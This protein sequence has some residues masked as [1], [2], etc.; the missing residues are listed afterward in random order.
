MDILGIV[1]IL[2]VL[3]ALVTFI[4]VIVKSAK[5]WGAIHVTT[6]FFLFFAAWVFLFS[7]AGVLDTRVKWIRSHDTERAAVEN[8]E[9]EV[10]KIK[11]GDLI[12]TNYDPNS[13]NATLNELGRMKLDRGRIWRGIQLQSVDDN[14]ASY[15]LLAPPNNAAA[16]AAPAAP[17]VAP[18]APPADGGSI[19]VELVVYAFAETKSEDGRIVPGTYLGQFI[20]ESV[21]GDALKL[22]P[23]EELTEYQNATISGGGAATWTVFE[24][25]PLDSHTAFASKGSEQN[26]KQLFGRMDPAELGTLF[27]ADPAVLEST[28]GIFPN[29][30]ELDPNIRQAALLRAYLADGQPTSEPL[31]PEL[32]WILV[33]F[34]KEHKIEV[35][36]KDTRIA[37][38]GG[39]FDLSGRTV[40][41]R[42]KRDEG[43]ATITF[44][45]GDHEVFW[46]LPAED[47]IAQDVAKLI[48]RY[49][50]RPLNDYK[51]GFREIRERAIKARQGI[52]LYTHENAV[53]AATNQEGQ[54]QIA[55][56]QAEKRALDKDVAQFTKESTFITSEVERLES[57]LASINAKIKETYRTIQSEHARLISAS[58]G[59]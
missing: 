16:P 15:S 49:Y 14:G 47:L 31:P 41:A 38:E 35:D 13:L 58:K 10:S 50:V 43:D 30:F 25:M 19:P 46:K 32:E 26:E 2:V 33:E 8:L 56:R 3:T 37:T 5:G 48:D 12:A 18:A 9:A 44:R 51:L 11:N 42:L 1:F 6:L 27:P 40:D 7:S 53:I 17:G 36:S 29:G 39:F 24:L 28:A 57:E 23:T 45:P 22:R 59:K 55:F 54:E 52:E 4:V 20:V 21:Q 34:T